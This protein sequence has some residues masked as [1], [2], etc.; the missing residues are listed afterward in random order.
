MSFWGYGSE[1]D[2][3]GASHREGAERHE[4]ARA[5]IGRKARLTARALC[6]FPY[7]AGDAGLVVRA[8]EQ[9]PPT[10]FSERGD[11]YLF[12]QM[13]DGGLARCLLMGDEVLLEEEYLEKLE[14]K[15]K[16]EAEKA[17]K[18]VKEESPP[19]PE[20]TP[21]APQPSAAE[22]VSALRAKFAR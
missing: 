5:L 7:K 8:Q 12:L 11:T 15:K 9:A 19:A 4:R 6:V 10:C 13:E 21:P 3:L 22:L 18:E 1:D 2:P 17:A 14:K 16:E 20:A